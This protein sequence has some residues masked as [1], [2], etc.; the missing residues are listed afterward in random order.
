MTFVVIFM[1]IVVMQCTGN[2]CGDICDAIY[3]WY[4]WW[5]YFWQ[6]LWCV[7]CDFWYLWCAICDDICDVWSGVG[8]T[9]AA[10]TSILIAAPGLHLL[11]LCD[12]W[13]QILWIFWHN[14]FETNILNLKQVPNLNLCK[15]RHTIFWLKYGTYLW[16]HWL[17][18]LRD[19][20]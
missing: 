6:Y 18:I 3:R 2:I 10:S 17:T 19:R 7:I 4:Q 11:G 14:T 20:F 15:A 8:W 12:I 13:S 16:K 5:L 9:S 1:M